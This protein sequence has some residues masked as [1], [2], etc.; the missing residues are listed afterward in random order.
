M[1][2]HAAIPMSTNNTTIHTN[3]FFPLALPGD[4]ATGLNVVPAF[5]ARFATL[6]GFSLGLDDLGLAICVIPRITRF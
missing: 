6:D 3:Q 1:N 5:D 4:G 2:A